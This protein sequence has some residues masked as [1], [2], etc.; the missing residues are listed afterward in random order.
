MVEAKCCL[1]IENPGR[2]SASTLRS[3]P[4][5]GVDLGVGCD[6]RGDDSLEIVGGMMAWRSIEGACVEA[7]LEVGSM[8]S[9]EHGWGAPNLRIY[10]RAY[11]SVA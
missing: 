3:D 1:R 4:A 5:W 10:L 9:M 6:V 7:A 11:K 8:R 2:R